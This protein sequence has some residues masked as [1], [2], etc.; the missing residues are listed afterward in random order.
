[1]LFIN[2]NRRAPIL[3]GD[4]E[5]S[6][7]GDKCFVEYVKLIAK[8]RKERRWTTA[9]NEFKRVLTELFGWTWTD[10]ETAKFLALME[11]YAREVHRYES[12]KVEENGDIQ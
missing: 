3:A 5:P 6:E 8:W 7:V 12:E 9:H 4:L 1:M 11:F 2:P 10:T